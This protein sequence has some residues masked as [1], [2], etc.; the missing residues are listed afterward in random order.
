MSNYQQKPN[1]S[2]RS[3]DPRHLW[4]LFC[5][6][7]SGPRSLLHLRGPVRP[8]VGATGDHKGHGRCGQGLPGK[9]IQ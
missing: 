4:L 5:P 8:G 7:G 9:Q 6:G 3:Q 1:L 2:L